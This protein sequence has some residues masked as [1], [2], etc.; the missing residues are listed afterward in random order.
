MMGCIEPGGLVRLTSEDLMGEVVVWECREEEVDK[1]ARRRK[2]A[3]S[4]EARISNG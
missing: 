3:R 2:G 1:G 4:K